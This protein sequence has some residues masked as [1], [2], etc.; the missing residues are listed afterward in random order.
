VSKKGIYHNFD[1]S[2]ECDLKKVYIHLT[3]NNQIKGYKLGA[4]NTLKKLWEINFSEEP[5]LQIASQNTDMYQPGEIIGD[6]ELAY[7]FVDS[8]VIAVATYN[9]CAL[10]GHIRP[11]NLS[12][13]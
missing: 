8:N 9:V 2:I 6:R 5:I 4:E 12:H 11:L 3:E 1:P 13:Q 10:A 7:K